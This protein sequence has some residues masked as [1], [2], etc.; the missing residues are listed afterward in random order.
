MLSETCKRIES[1]TSLV[2]FYWLLS[3]TRAAELFTNT[4][5]LDIKDWPPGSLLIELIP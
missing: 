1:S 2:S 3:A 4:K 5:D